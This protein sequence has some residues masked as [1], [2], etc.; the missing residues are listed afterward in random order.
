MQLYRLFKIDIW[1]I[2]THAYKYVCNSVETVLPEKE[3]LYP[4]RT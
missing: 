1:R 2:S 4:N 3:H